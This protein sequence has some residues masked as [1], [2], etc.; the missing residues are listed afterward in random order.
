MRGCGFPQEH[1]DAPSCIFSIRTGKIPMLP[2]HPWSAPGF[3]GSNRA[4][5]APISAIHSLSKIRCFMVG[6]RSR[7]YV[8]R[9]RESQIVIASSL[10]L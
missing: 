9:D 5:C 7:T 8:D 1:A 3:K 6:R 10:A 2:A 4:T